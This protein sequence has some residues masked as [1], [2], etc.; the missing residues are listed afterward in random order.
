MG[1]VSLFCGGELQNCLSVINLPAYCL[2]ANL[3]YQPSL[4]HK[5]ILGFP[6][7][8]NILAQL[9]LL[10]TSSDMESLFSPWFIFRA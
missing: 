9:V 2:L 6:N 5:S 1:C 8:L 10:G 7:I 3:V 4:A